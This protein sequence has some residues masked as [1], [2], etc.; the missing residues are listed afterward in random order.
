MSKFNPAKILAC[1]HEMLD[2]FNQGQY[3]LDAMRQLT[4]EGT[5]NQRSPP[6][7]VK[8]TELRDNDD[9]REQRSELQRDIRQ[10]REENEKLQRDVRD[11][12]MDSPGHSAQYCTYTV[13]DEKTRAI[14]AVEVVDKRQTDRKSSIMEKRGFE[15]AMDKLLEARVPIE[16][17]LTKGNTL[18]VWHGAK[19]LIKKLIAAGQEK[20]CT[21]LKQWT[22]DI[23]NHFWWCCNKAS[24]FG[25]FIVLW[26]GVLHHVCDV[27]TWAMGQCDHNPISADTP[28]TKTWLVSGSP[29]HKKLATIIL[30]PRWLKTTHKYLR[31]RTTSDLESFQNHLLMYAS[32]RYAFSPPVY[33]ARCQLAALDYNEH[34]D[35]AVWKAKDGHIK[36]KRRF[37]K[38]SEP[39]EVNT[40]TFF[41]KTPG[42]LDWKNE[43]FTTLSRKEYNGVPFGQKG[44]ASQNVTHSF[45][46]RARRY[47][48]NR[49]GICD[50]CKDLRTARDQTR[51]A[52]K[53]RQ[54]S[55]GKV[56]SALEDP[57]SKL[58]IIIDGMD[59]SKTAIPHF[60]QRTKTTVEVAK[61]MMSVASRQKRLFQPV[62]DKRPVSDGVRRANLAKVLRKAVPEAA[63]FTALEEQ[64][65]QKEDDV[66]VM[67]MA[68]RDQSNSPI[69]SMSRR[70]RI[71]ASNF[72]GVYTEV[73]TIK[74][75]PDTS[76][77]AL[78]AKIMG[79]TRVS[80]SIPALKYGRKMEDEAKNSLFG[81]FC[82]E[83]EAYLGASPD[84]MFS[85]KCHE[86]V[87]VEV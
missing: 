39:L 12:R 79:C 55:W 44:Q 2:R 19:N 30:N 6:S 46:E 62:V 4:D 25:E 67:E 29:A 80:E 10:L 58:S 61:L 50:V 71:T 18:D 11:G 41:L 83:H 54:V 69:W 26:K 82:R 33:E 23:I 47:Q 53:E 15:K 48:K 49:L 85:C 27:H 34:K 72:Y 78:L 36:Y 73:K 17:M 65:H 56:Y 59:Q 9:L 5:A 63:F 84:A 28:R 45:K 87:V 86:E 31:F 3:I 7:H 75:K 24:T 81:T 77:D 14:V 21:D 37:Q 1:R 40:I 22:R 20:S 8:D 74:S 16:E 66:H 32:K 52:E 13:L 60:M 38:K 68:T 64:P 76:T 51:S 57:A 70:G 35:R 42:S 43:V